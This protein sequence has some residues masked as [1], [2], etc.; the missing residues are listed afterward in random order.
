MNFIASMADGTELF[1][2]HTDGKPVTAVW[3]QKRLL[4][5]W[6][7]GLGMMKEGGACKL[8]LPPELAF[9]VSGNGSIPPNS[10]IIMEVELLSVKP[11]PKPTTVAAADLKS[12]DGG[13]QYSDLTVGTGAEA[14]SGTIVTTD[15]TLWI[16]AGT[17]YT[18]VDSSEGATAVN[19]VIGAKDTVF[20][21]WENGVIGMKAGGKRYLVIPPLLGI[22]SQGNSYIPANSTLVMEI[23]L[24]EVREQPTMTKIDEKDYT[25]TASGLKYYDIQVGTGVTPTVGQTVVVHYSGWLQDGTLFDSSVVRGEPFTFQVGTGSVIPGWDEGVASMKAGVNASS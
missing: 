23:V 9:G 24:K 22:G 2:T 13:L 1:N 15:Y 6:E 4:A 21:G 7:E 5:G 11:A 8:V 3:G 14:I 17:V 16:Q 25:T 18:Y 10:Q 20:P 19:F 12:G